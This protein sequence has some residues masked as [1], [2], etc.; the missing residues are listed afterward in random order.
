[1]K[2]E[3]IAK[4]MLD[5]CQASFDN[6]YSAN[7]LLQEQMERVSQTVLDQATW[8]PD[9]GRQAI[10]NWIQSY[11]SYRENFKKYVDDSYRGVEELLAG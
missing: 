5:F 8:I 9:E 6:V 1:M 4:Q 10:N 2:Q 11:K 3:H 7:T